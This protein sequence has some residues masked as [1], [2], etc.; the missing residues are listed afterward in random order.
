MS[1]LP[2]PEALITP[3]ILGCKSRIMW[4]YDPGEPA[5]YW[6]PGEP[7]FFNAVKGCVERHLE[8][9]STGDDYKAVI[10]ELYRQLLQWELLQQAAFMNQRNSRRYLG[11]KNRNVNYNLRPRIRWEEL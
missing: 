4:E 5:T 2:P 1:Y 7:E 10:G 6:Y 8:H 3:C 11:A 9:L